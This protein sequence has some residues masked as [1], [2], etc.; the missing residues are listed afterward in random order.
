MWKFIPSTGNTWKV[1]FSGS[2]LFT[3]P[4]DDT[5][6]I[7][8][9]TTRPEAGLHPT[10]LPGVIV[11]FGTGKYI[12]NGD[13]VGD[14]NVNRF[15][16]VWDLWNEGDTSTLSYHS[17][18]IPTT[19]N[20][21]VSGGNLLRQC[22]TTGTTAETC[23][24]N[25][26]SV[27][28]EVL[29]NHE[30]RFISSNSISVWDWVSTNG[31]MGWYLDLPEYGEKQ[32]SRS[33]LRAGR[34][35]F[36]TVVPSEHSCSSGG[37]SWLME[38]DAADGSALDIPVFDLNLDGT[39]DEDDMKLVDTDGDGEN[40]TQ[41]IPGG[42]RSKEGIIQPPSILINTDTGKEFKFSSGSTGNIEKT[43]EN[44]G[45]LTIGRKSWVQL[46]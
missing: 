18:T 37:E 40:D 38:L 2:P 28:G 27:S 42:K 31:K 10:G 26:A 45:E 32:V 11:Y 7:Q 29:Q 19:P 15:Y 17:R 21:S 23:V 4:A 5:G 41:L 44:P 25:A 36:I 9:I 8:P 20:I 30:V 22:V 3:A 46:K 6:Y 33:I 43:T 35:I 13:N 39:F 34:I 1:A 24:A 14:S 12:E 16:A